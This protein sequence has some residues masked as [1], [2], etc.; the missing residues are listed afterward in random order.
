MAICGQ[1]CGGCVGIDNKDEN[2]KAFRKGPL[3]SKGELT[4]QSKKDFRKM[5][6][7]KNKSSWQNAQNSTFDSELTAGQFRGS[8]RSSAFNY[9]RK[10]DDHRGNKHS[11]RDQRQTQ[12]RTRSKLRDGSK[13]SKY[14]SDH[15]MQE[16]Y[17]SA[18]NSLYGKSKFYYRQVSDNIHLEDSE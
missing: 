1:T 17:N 12:R 13:P 4:E 6:K 10:Y 14:N 11:N 5:V 7:N 16:T 2:S 15:R 8:H 18:D 3:N 9:S